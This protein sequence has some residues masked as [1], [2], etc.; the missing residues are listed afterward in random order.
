MKIT[1]ISLILIDLNDKIFF[2]I[3]TIV[4]FEEE[5]EFI[6]NKYFQYQFLVTIFFLIVTPLKSFRHKQD[7][8]GSIRF[9]TKKTVFSV[10]ST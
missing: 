8:K 7:Q 6:Q 3:Q 9:L 4:M 5:S 1:I 10:H 2:G